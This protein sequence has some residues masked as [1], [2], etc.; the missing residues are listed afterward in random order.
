LLASKEQQLASYQQMI[1]EK[2]QSEN[3]QLTQKVLDKINDYVK[4]Y[5]NEHDYELILASTQY[6]NIVYGIEDVDIT[7]EIIEGLN[8][9]YKAP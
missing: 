6:G 8:R 5:G 1:Q 2:V 3:L 4:R 9:E 7:Q